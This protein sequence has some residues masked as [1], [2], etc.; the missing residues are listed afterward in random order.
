M[1]LRFLEK[2]AYNTSISFSDGE[3]MAVS[4]IRS[5]ILYVVVLIGVRIIGKRQIGQ[6]QPFELVVMMLISDI[7]AVPMQD[8]ALP[9]VSGLIPLITIIA[10]EVLLSAVVMKKHGIRRTITGNPLA[11]IKDGV[12]IQN[13]LH[14][15]NFTVDDLIESMRLSG[16]SDPSQIDYAVLETNGDVSFFPKNGADTSGFFIPVICDGEIID[17]NLP[18]YSHDRKWIEKELSSRALSCSDVFL[19]SV[20][21]AGQLSVVYKE[22]QQ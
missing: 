10:L 20:N 22:K 11:I 16:Y 5:I 4:F 14:H 9:L 8:T 12:I 1:F 19:M 6:L 21:K 17:K 18:F 15:V 2:N 3:K 7:A 13:A